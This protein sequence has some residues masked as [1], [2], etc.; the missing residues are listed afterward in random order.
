MTQ[1]N[2]HETLTEQA[3]RIV[4]GLPISNFFIERCRRELEAGFTEDQIVRCVMAGTWPSSIEKK[5]GTRG[6]S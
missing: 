6:A 1:R 3:T 2:D 5:F 4:H